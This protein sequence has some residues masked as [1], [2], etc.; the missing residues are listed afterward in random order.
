MFLVLLFAGIYGCVYG[1]FLNVL[2]YRWPRRLSLWHPASHCPECKTPIKPYD[3]I[4]LISYLLLRGHCRHCRARFSSRYF[5]VELVS[6]I[7]AVGAFLAHGVTVYAFL[8]ALEVP[9]LLA[10]LL[11]LRDLPEGKKEV[12]LERKAAAFAFLLAFA[13]FLSD[14]L[15]FSVIFACTALV[16]V[17]LSCH[18]AKAAYEAEG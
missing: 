5:W 12:A 10:A 3:N 14:I 11:M 13:L 6:G 17:A 1:S 8:I 7:V 18:E 2:I 9:L 16:F 15:F 4:P